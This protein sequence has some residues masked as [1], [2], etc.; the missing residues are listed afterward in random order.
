M[1]QSP[2]GSYRRTIFGRRTRCRISFDSPGLAFHRSQRPII[3]PSVIA[4][5]GGRSLLRAQGPFPEVFGGPIGMAP[6]SSS[7]KTPCYS[8]QASCPSL[9]ISFRFVLEAT[10]ERWAARQELRL[11]PLDWQSGHMGSYPRLPLSRAY[12]PADYEHL[13]VSAEIKE[14][15]QYIS[16]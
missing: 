14:L 10:R 2:S 5:F 12:N 15:F 9:I 8:Q 3:R 6:Q 16:R 4:V 7:M 1:R 13:P 11:E